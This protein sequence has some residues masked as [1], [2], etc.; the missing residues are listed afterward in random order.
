MS[1]SRPEGE[2][3]RAEKADLERDILRRKAQLSQVRI[4]DLVLDVHKKEQES[5]PTG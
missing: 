4:N 2:D 3:E 5:L 1:H